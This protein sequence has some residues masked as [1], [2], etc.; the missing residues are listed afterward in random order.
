MKPSASDHLA[1]ERTFLA[2]LR[3]A[4]A[5][6]GFGFVV[7]RFGIFVRA[8]AAAEHVAARGS[9]SSTPLGIVMVAAGIAIAIFGLSRYLAVA[10]ALATGGPTELSTRNATGIVTLL[11]LFGLIVAY[12]LYRAGGL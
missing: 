2:Y 3:T 4:I 9:G 5:S 6:I 7:A 11:A 8:S 1:N 12:L 10:R